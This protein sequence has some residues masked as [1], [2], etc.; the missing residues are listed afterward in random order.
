MKK[1]KIGYT[2]GVFDM[3]HVGH[4]NLLEK[5]KSMCDYLIVGVCN[6]DYVRNIKH[7]EPVY[8]EQDRVRILEALKV[9]D[10]AELVTI[11]ETNDK[12]LAIE[13]F[14]FDVLFSG[15]DWKGSERYQKTEE[16]FKKYGAFIEY[17]PYTQG[18]STT[19]IK[20]KIKK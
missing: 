20:E 12:I 14:H 9:V 17:F 11:E 5:C 1:Y 8:S 6:D 18:I 19:Q 2:C 15:D 7:K 16:Q 10:R 4:L 13:K 3:F